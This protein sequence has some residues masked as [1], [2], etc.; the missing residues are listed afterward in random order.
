M[1]WNYD[2]S[3]VLKGNLGVMDLLATNE[4]KRPIY[5]TSTV[6]ANQYMGLEKYF[7]QEG[8]SYKISPI[9]IDVKAGNTGM[10]DPFTMYDNMMN[11]F[12]WG[13]AEDPEV[14][15]DENNRRIFCNFRNTFGELG[16]A[17]LEA[18]DT[19]KAI[20]VADK[21]MMLVPPEKM[22]YDYYMI[23][24]AETYL[25]AGETEKGNALVGTII[26]YAKEYLNYLVSIDALNKYGLDLP[27]GINMQPVIDI[28]RMAHNLGLE[29][30]EM[31]TESIVND[32]YYLLFAQ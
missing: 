10:I 18:G 3:Y 5:F 9:K 20:E 21:G 16:L 14:Y 7:V 26:N 32:Y 4:W 25:R 15:L 30:L 2:L 17:L 8:L 19:T 12:T 6:P 27:K 31:A 13:N 22:P 28:Y 23:G 11:K 24:I 1:V 29:D